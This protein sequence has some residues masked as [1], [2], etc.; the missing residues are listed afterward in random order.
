MWMR[1]TEPLL[2][3][4]TGAWDDV[5]ERGKDVIAWDRSRGTTQIT[6]IILSLQ[7]E[8]LVDRDQVADATPIADELLPM[9]RRTGD[10]Q[11][12]MEALP[13]VARL[14]LARGDL[15]AA[16]GLIAEARDV[17]ASNPAWRSHRVAD[18]VRTAIA[19]GDVE[20][21][22]SLLSNVDTQ[23][24]RA[25]AAVLSGRAALAEALRDAASA[26]ELYGDSAR[27]WRDFGHRVE[28][29][30]ALLGLGRALSALGRAADASAA[31]A[32]A[33]AIFA[34]MKASALVALVDATVRPHTTPLA[35]ADSR[36]R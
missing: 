4:E 21:A 31:L 12:L 27:R 33:R 13:A 9:A 19:A 16:R 10:V 24:P 11:A 14:E 35:R 28:L 2:L 26:I 22:R 7:V 36:A 5:L 6:R 8:I 18:C 1:A 32:D 20:L 29:G 25:Q 30:H 34:E 3:F 17:S 23:V 15:T